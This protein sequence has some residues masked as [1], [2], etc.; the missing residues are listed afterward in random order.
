M[1]VRSLPV[2][3]VLVRIDDGVNKV[4]ATSGSRLPGLI[5]RQRSCI[6]SNQRKHAPSLQRAASLVSASF[7]SVQSAGGGY[8][9]EPA[10]IRRRVPSPPPAIGGLAVW[11][12]ISPLSRSVM[13]TGKKSVYFTFR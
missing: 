4:S 7:R 1:R 2:C 8:A 13:L 5:G 3:C 9:G 6:Q 10:A 12:Q 11:S